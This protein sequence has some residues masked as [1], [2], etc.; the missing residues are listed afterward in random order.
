MGAAVTLM[1]IGSVVAKAAEIDGPVLGFHRAWGAAIVYGLMLL[2]IGG[3]VTKRALR[4]AAPGGTIFGIQLVLFFS[5]IQ[6]TT[7]ANATMLIALQPVVVLLFFSRRFGETVTRREWVLS[8]IAILGVGLVVFGSVDSPSWS[9][10]GDALGVG[11][12][13]SWTLYFVFSKRAREHLGAV[14]YQSLSLLFSAAVL[15]PIAL[16]FGGTLDPGPGKWWWIPAMVAIPGT[17]HLLLNWAHPRVSLGLVSQL[18]LISPVVSVALAAFVLEGE[19][20]NAVQIAGMALVVC[21]LA[22]IVTDRS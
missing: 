5:S 15:L 14:E 10:T 18:T 11:A 7:V 16:I 8:S 9:V 2:A 3:R 21:A 4:L 20:V 19:T 22:A 17:G 13:L 12:L 1:G 6:L